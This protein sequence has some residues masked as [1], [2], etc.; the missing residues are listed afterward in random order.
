MNIILDLDNTLISAVEL[1][2]YNEKTNLEKSRK[3]ESF[4]VDNYYKVFKRPNVDK[5]IKFLF[6]NCKHVSVWSAGTKDYVLKIVDE[7]FIKKGYHPHFVFFLYHCNLSDKNHKGIKDLDMVVKHF[8]YDKDKTYIVDD[9]DDVIHIN[10]Q[11]SFHIKDFEYY[12]KNSEN[13]KELLR[14]MEKIKKINNQI[15]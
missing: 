7:L 12:N 11:N 13:D 2:G 14:I 15:A 9:L 4:D 10:K 5:F 1:D 3:F 6:E 8:K